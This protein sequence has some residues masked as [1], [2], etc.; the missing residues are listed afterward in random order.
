MKLQIKRL[1]LERLLA[2]SKNG[3]A[4]GIDTNEGSIN[5][6]DKTG[7]VVGSVNAAIDTWNTPQ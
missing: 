7:K 1:H 3:E 2:N 5:L 6:I 4:I